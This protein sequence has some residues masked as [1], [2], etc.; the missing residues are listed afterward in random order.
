MVSALAEILS[1][2]WHVTDGLVHRTSEEQGSVGMHGLTPMRSKPSEASS[3]QG[4]YHVKCSCLCGRWEPGT[5]QLPELSPFNDR[6]G[7]ARLCCGLASSTLLLRRAPLQTTLRIFRNGGY[8]EFFLSHSHLG[9]PLSFLLPH[10]LFT[11]SRELAMTIVLPW[12]GTG[13]NFCHF[14]V[15]TPPLT[16]V[17]GCT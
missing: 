8:I 10:P 12:V 9:K 3:S 15:S 5:Q 6:R 17:S 1:C 2:S 16:L 13:S 14:P 11:Q 7:C 4:S